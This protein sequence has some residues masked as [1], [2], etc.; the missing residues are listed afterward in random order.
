MFKGLSVFFETYS[1]TSMDSKNSAL[2]P[3]D[4]SCD[5]DDSIKRVQELL[6]QLGYDHFV[7][8]S[9]FKEL[10]AKNEIFEVTVSFIKRINGGTHIGMALFSPKGKRTKKILIGLM[11]ELSQAFTN[12]II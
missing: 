9:N 3:I 5:I 4:V 12:E 10:F 6:S 11:Q 1:I 7:V 8:D 2:H